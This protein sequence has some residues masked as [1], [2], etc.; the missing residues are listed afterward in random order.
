MLAIERPVFHIE[1]DFQF[2]LA[3]KIQKENP[4]AEIRLEYRVPEF[5]GRYTDIWIKAEN[6]IAIELKYKPVS[7]A[8]E[9]KG[10]FFELKKQGAQDLGRYDFLKDVQRVEEIV[11]KYP[12][13]TGYAIIL[14]NDHL[15]WKSSQKQNPIDAAFRI[16]EGKDIHGVLS[17][18]EKAGKKTKENRE[19]P[20]SIKGHYKSKWTTYSSVNIQKFGEFK[21]L[22]FKITSSNYT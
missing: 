4:D 11:L 10:E 19:D 6:P 22:L 2:A 21:M 7:V 16:H 15:Y 5:P 20:I 14:T 17:W 13:T 1:V 12:K 18:S 8:L 9:S 3:W